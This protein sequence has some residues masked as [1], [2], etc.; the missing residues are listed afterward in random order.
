MTGRVLYTGQAIVDIVMLIPALPQPGGD[1]FASHSEIT[2][3][4]GFNALAAA[5]R[6]G[7]DVV[8]LGVIGT[9]PF[10]DVVAAALAAEGV[11]MPAPRVPDADSGFSVAMTD[12]TTERTFVSALGAEDAVDVTVLDAADVAAED[13]VIVSGYS[14]LGGR[15]TD[16]L[17]A[18]VPMLPA[19]TRVL[20]DPSPLVA[21]LTPAA[22]QVVRDHADIW[23]LNAREAAE[24]LRRFGT[25]VPADFAARAR[26]LA[27][28]VA[29]AVIVRDGATGADLSTGEHIPAFAVTAVDTNGAGDAHTGVLASALARGLALPVAVRRANAAAALAVTRPGPATA[30]TR[31][32]TNA[33]LAR[34]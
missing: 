11:T 13:V 16:A 22:W 23:S 17:I 32:V 12:D 21:D 20:F 7:A 34:G 31:A 15:N 14:L 9:G 29:G 8:H 6:D 2:A 33:L 30:P 24:A 25:E 4:G 26:A 3:G 10:G 19:A 28:R 1:V 27:E 5:A 18:W